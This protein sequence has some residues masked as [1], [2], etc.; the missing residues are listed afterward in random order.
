MRYV[1]PETKP[2]SVVRVYWQYFYINIESNI[3]NVKWVLV[4]LQRIINLVN[5]VLCRFQS[6]FNSL[7]VWAVFWLSPTR[8]HF[9]SVRVSKCSFNKNTYKCKEIPLCS[10][11]T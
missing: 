10:F 8:S 6:L 11:V 4:Q 5:E 1:A 9:C 2:N 3:C 7:F